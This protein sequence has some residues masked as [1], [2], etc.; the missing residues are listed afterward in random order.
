MPK[1]IAISDET[2]LLIKQKEIELEKKYGRTIKISSITD[3]ILRKN[4]DNV[5]DYLIERGIL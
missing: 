3:T 2:H 4:L 5:E 1:S